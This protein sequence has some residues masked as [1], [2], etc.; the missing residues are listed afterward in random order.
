LKALS[1]S[2]ITQSSISVQFIDSL[3]T[4]PLLSAALDLLGETLKS[5]LPSSKKAKKKGAAANPL[6]EQVTAEIVL[7]LKQ[8]VK[9]FTI[10]YSTPTTSID[11]AA[12][13]E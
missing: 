4:T 3:F 1:T 12:R 8:I 13:I 10:V 6:I 2:D 9:D 7:P 11:L 5:V